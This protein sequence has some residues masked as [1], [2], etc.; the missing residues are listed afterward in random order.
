MNLFNL[1]TDAT[2]LALYDRMADIPPLAYEM[3]KARKDQGLRRS[4]RLE[5]AILKDVKLAGD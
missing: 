2:K 1:H 4:P 5:A 3:A